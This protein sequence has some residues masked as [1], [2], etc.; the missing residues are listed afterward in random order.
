MKSS[1][2]EI[3][4]KFERRSAEGLTT[5]QQDI[6]HKLF[7]IFHRDSPVV[8]PV[9]IPPAKLNGHDPNSLNKH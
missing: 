8:H 7:A 2:L 1:L 6:V 4:C 3:V 9:E 5:K